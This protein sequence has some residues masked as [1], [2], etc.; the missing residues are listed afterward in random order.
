MIGM[1]RLGRRRSGPRGRWEIL[2]IF[3][4][5]QVLLFYDPDRLTTQTLPTLPEAAVSV[6]GTKLGIKV[7]FLSLSLDHP[8]IRARVCRARARAEL[9][10]FGRP[11]FR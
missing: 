7:A 6:L 9:P 2:A 11:R 8:F 5:V 1:R 4:D 10:G 3:P